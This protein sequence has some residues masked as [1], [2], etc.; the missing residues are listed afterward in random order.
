MFP[1]R[2]RAL[3]PLLAGVLLSCAPQPEPTDVVMLPARFADEP[4]AEPLVALEAFR[5]DTRFFIRYRTRGETRYTG[6][7]WTDRIQL[8]SVASGGTHD[9][10]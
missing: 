3:I 7:T 8:D 6:G 9:G 2:T 1:R 4:L 10:P 5:D